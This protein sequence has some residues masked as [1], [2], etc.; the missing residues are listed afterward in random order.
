[1]CNDNKVSI[2]FYSILFY[3]ILIEQPICCTGMFY[4]IIYCTIFLHYYNIITYSYYLGFWCKHTYICVYIFTYK[5]ICLS[6]I[7]IRRGSSVNKNM[8][9]SGC[10]FIRVLQPRFGVGVQVARQP[11]SVW[12]KLTCRGEQI[13]VSANSVKHAQKQRCRPGPARLKL[14]CKTR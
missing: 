10:C 6:D 14:R 13:E 7:C 2:L 3:S 8:T 1:M 11:L 5:C 9:L 4:Y 12:V